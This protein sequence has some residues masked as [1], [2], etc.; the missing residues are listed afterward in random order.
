MGA[1][2]PARYPEDVFVSITDGIRRMLSILSVLKRPPEGALTRH[3]QF[4][5]DIA[6]RAWPIFGVIGSS[7]PQRTAFQGDVFFMRFAFMAI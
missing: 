6:L 1:Q 2:L 3:R 7:A 4:R 5:L